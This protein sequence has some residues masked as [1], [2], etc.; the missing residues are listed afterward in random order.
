MR[1]LRVIAAGLL[2]ALAFGAELGGQRPGRLAGDLG[3][4]AGAQPAHCRAYPEV[5]ARGLFG[6][7]GQRRSGPV[8][9][10]GRQP[11][12]DL[13]GAVV[14][15]RQPQCP[16]RGEMGRRR[17]PVD[18]PVVAGRQDLPARPRPR[19]RPATAGGH[20]HGRRMGR[21]PE[22]GGGAESQARLPCRDRAARDR[23]Q[24]RQPRPGQL[25]RAPVVHLAPGRPCAA[26][27]ETGRVCDLR[28]PHRP[29][30][31]LEHPVHPGR[32][33]PAPGPEAAAAGRGLALAGPQ[34]AR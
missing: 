21:D 30:P 2:L 4:H 6:H 12:R 10:A 5:A 26:R 9:R 34:G 8:R 19:G 29:R 3:G 1:L 17:R 18:R 24:R 25:R 33:D 27:V 20:R 15:H 14:R 31:D 13:R 28:R 11:G 16:L 32:H 22:H 7:L 23:G